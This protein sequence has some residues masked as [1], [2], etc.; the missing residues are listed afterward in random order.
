[1]GKMALV[2]AAD[3]FRVVLTPPV[4]CMADCLNGPC[5]HARRAWIL[6]PLWL[7]TGAGWTDRSPKPKSDNILCKHNV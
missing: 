1:M 5:D 4:L 3:G 6:P 2:G 7:E